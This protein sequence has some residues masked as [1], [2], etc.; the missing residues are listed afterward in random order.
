MVNEVETFQEC[1]FVMCAESRAK[2]NLR[3]L[4]RDLI[5]GEIKPNAIHIKPVAQIHSDRCLMTVK[6]KI[7]PTKL[8]ESSICIHN[9][10][11]EE[12]S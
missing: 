3:L 4:V 1:T 9:W 5:A 7:Q 12:L 11:S 10:M 8:I 2:M 6:W